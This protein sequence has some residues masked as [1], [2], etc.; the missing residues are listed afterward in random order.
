MENGKME[1]RYILLKTVSFTRRFHCMHFKFSVN[2][3]ICE[4]VFYVFNNLIITKR[5]KFEQQHRTTEKEHDVE[6]AHVH[7][8]YMFL[9]S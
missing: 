2:F 6:C 1:W 9:V 3:H 5:K 7:S 8:M 4:L